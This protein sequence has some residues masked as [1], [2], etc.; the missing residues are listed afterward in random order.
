MITCGWLRNE[1]ELDR[2]ATRPTA[3]QLANVKVTD[4]TMS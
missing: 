4:V 1:D 3:I 2:V